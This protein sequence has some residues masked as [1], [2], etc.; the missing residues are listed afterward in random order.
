VAGDRERLGMDAQETNNSLEFL[1]PDS[2]P[3]GRISEVIWRLRQAYP[4]A[5]C[6]LEHDNALQLLVATILSAQCTDVRVNQVTPPRMPGPSARVSQLHSERLVP[7]GSIVGCCD[8]KL[9][10]PR[11]V[12]LPPFDALLEY[13]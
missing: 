10:L 4:D 11:W 3:A 2:P 1:T 13:G 6:E 5:H 9:V 8:G 7:V 12:F